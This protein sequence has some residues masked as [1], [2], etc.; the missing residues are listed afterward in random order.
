M[1]NYTNRVLYT[2]VT[3]DLKKRVYQHKEGVSSGFTRRYN[4]KKLVYYEV[5]SDI[6]SAVTREK[7]IKKW[8]RQKKTDLVNS[9]IMSPDP[10]QAGRGVM[11]CTTAFPKIIT[12]S[13]YARLL[14]M[15]WFSR[16]SITLQPWW[17]RAANFQ[18]PDFRWRFLIVHLS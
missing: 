10:P 17:F 6:I 3:S 2:G 11:I 1:T 8:K 12:S 15:T 18:Q 16:I 7:Q 5:H 9:V 14:M 4:V 13:R